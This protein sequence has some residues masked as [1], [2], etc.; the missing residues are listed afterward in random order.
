MNSRLRALCLMGLAACGT[1]RLDAPSPQDAESEAS[2]IDAT[3]L[4]LDND[5]ATVPDTSAPDPRPPPTFDCLDAGPD[6][7]TCPLPHSLCEGDWL[8]YFDNGKCVDGTCHFTAAVK[9]CFYRCF[10]AGCGSFHGTA[11]PQ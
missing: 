10:E 8:E 7:S 6:A 11:P 2:Q 4:F 9:Q 1:S 3:L 5:G